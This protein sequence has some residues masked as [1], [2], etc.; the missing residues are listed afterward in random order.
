MTKLHDKA[1][2]FTLTGS[3]KKKHSLGDYKGKK[4]ILYFYPKDHTPGCT[5]EAKKFRDEYESYQNLNA[6]ILGVSRDSLE[7]HDQFVEDLDLPFTL[8]SDTEEK[9]STLYDVFKEKE[10]D[11][12]I[13]KGI[14]RSTFI[15]DEDGILIYEN[16]NVVPDNHAKE[17]AEFLKKR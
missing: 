16:R 11:G 17:I 14:Q 1:P 6:L 8:L 2:D 3:D 12:K 4:V 15:I 9:V 5:I 13:V 7:S 10:K